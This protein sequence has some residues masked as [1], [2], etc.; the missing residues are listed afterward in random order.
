MDRSMPPVRMHQVAG[1]PSLEHER[2]AIVQL[3]FYALEAEEFGI[4]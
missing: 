2:Q 4:Q 1:Q 3:G